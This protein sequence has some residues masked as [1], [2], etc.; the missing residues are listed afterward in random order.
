MARK[1]S[2]RNSSFSL[3]LIFLI[4]GWAAGQDSSQLPPELRSKIDTIAKSVLATTGVPSASIAVVTNGKIS[5]LNAYG[6]A[7]IDP[8]TP[9]RTDMRYAIGSISKQLD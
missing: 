8:A 9:A 3:I 2:M 7:R 5:Y 6:D 1:R 4:S